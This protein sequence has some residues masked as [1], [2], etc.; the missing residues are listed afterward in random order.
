MTKNTHAFLKHAIQRFV[1]TDL[2]TILEHN[3]NRPAENGFTIQACVKGK[4]KAQEIVR[5]M[6]TG[7]SIYDCSRSPG[8]HIM[9][10]N[11]A[12]VESFCEHEIEK[13]RNKIST[14]KEIT[15]EYRCFGATV[16]SYLRRAYS[17]LFKEE[18][19]VWISK[20]QKGEV[21]CVSV[22]H[23]QDPNDAVPLCI[24]EITTPDPEYIR[25][26]RWYEQRD[27][28]AEQLSGVFDGDINDE[29]T[30][31]YIYNVCKTRLQSAIKNYAGTAQH[32]LDHPNLEKPFSFEGWTELTFNDVSR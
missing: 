18:L 5:V 20:L 8:N 31:S 28:T 26:T 12:D 24:V 30:L 29:W 32:M 15:F 27:G 22:F 1:Y 4:R 2:R 3:K 25:V 11:M 10:N 7:Y 21:N 19:D 13:Y 17:A 14:D 9:Y 23:I 16:E 6:K